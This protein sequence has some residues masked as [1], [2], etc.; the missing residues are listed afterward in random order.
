MK[1]GEGDAV[2]PAVGRSSGKFVR[3]KF[4]RLLYTAVVVAAFAV[5]GC[6]V[7]E[8]MQVDKGKHP[9]NADENVRFRTTYYFR[10]YDRCPGTD[11]VKVDSLYRFRMTGKANALSTNVKFESGTLKAYQIDPFGS[12]VI[13]DKETGQFQ[14]QSQEAR[15]SAFQRAEARKQ[16][17][18]L[19][20]MRGRLKAAGVDDAA[21]SAKF[22]AGMAAAA[23]RLSAIDADGAGSPQMLKTLLE[24]QDLL[25]K[26]G[27]DDDARKLE[28]V[29][30]TLA[31]RISASDGACPNGV[32]ARR[33]FQMLGPQG[34][35]PFNQ[36]DRLI[37]A[38]R[39]SARPLISTLSE[40]SSRVLKQQP[41]AEA[42]VLPL[43]K[44]RLKISRAARLAADKGE[45]MDASTVDRIIGELQ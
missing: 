41:S 38:M 36:D 45:A 27:L 21:M 34:V 35:V 22:S 39:T 7:P 25:K 16:M 2:A 20:A 17:N 32:K 11:D 6:T 10:V 3:F 9:R 28:G 26:A 44:E 42:S 30:A 4:V 31:D 33:G 14:Y 23:D 5:G 15:Q 37:L 1:D 29:I 19:L 43:L 40:L 12:S 8:H 18:E 13:Y 24:L